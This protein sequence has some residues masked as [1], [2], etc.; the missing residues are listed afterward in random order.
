MIENVIRR[1]IEAAKLAA[2]KKAESTTTASASKKPVSPATSVL[3]ATPEARKLSADF[4]TN[5][6]K[7]P[8]PVTEGYISSR[9]GLQSHPIWRDVSVNNS[10]IDINSGKGAKVHA[11]FAGKVTK[12]IMIMNKYAVIMQHGEYFSVYSNLKDVYVKSGEEIPTKQVIG[13]VM[14]DDEDKS[15]VHFEIWKGSRKMD[16]EG[17]LASRR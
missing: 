12:V 1:E 11:V 4:E 6:G 5:K 15:E 14:T 8:W 2:R 10:G 9:Y 7:L 3:L 17:W 13:V 16:P